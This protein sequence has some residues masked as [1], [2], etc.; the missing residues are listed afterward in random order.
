M[1]AFYAAIEQRDFPEYRNK[2]LVVGGRPRGR[3]VV[4]TASY[5]ARK[6]GIKSAMPSSKA[7]RLC[8]HAIFVKPRFEVYKQV[9]QQLREIFFEYTDLV[10]PLSLDEA[11]LDV[12]ENK[13]GIPSATL[14]AR[15]IRQRIKEETGLTA[16]AGVAPNKFLAKVASDVNKPDGLT[17]IRPTEVHEFIEK[18]PIGRFHGIGKVTERR[19]N[20]LGIYTGKDLKTFSE[21][22]LAK[23]FGKA[24]RYYYRIAQGDD[25]REVKP[26]RIRKSVGAERTFSEDLTDIDDMKSRLSEIADEIERRLEKAGT[27]GKTVTLKVRYNN[28]ERVTRSFTVNEYIHEKQRFLPLCESLLQDTE[29]VYRPVRLL[30]ITIS[31]LDIEDKA[32]DQGHQ[33]ELQFNMGP[34]SSKTV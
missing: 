12:S 21:L 5:E 17:V 20:E 8:P 15:E 28:F 7:Y 2:P 23:H 25:Q 27:A 33:L 4:A 13:P 19:M 16:S 3:G 14:I 26:S 1:D 9:S 24:G 22:E 29:V 34:Q 30:G 32:S 18:L 10:E 6:F 31:S 11:Y